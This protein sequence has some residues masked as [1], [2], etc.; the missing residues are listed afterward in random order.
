MSES[1]KETNILVVE[2]EK[3]MANALKMKLESN[4]FHVD[5]ANE[6]NEALEALDNTDYAIML[7][8][9]VM[10]HMDGFDVL[11][12]VNERESSPRVIVLSNLS[13][14]ED[15]QKAQKLGAEEYYVKSNTS[16][17][18]IVDHVTQMVK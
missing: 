8:D 14:E 3:P 7:L 16:I 2:D 6:G 12:N 1:T 4:G 9:I 5:I 18:D 11:E 10:P 13:Q 15:K 17:S